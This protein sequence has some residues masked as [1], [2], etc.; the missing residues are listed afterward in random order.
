M[1][2]RASAEVEGKSVRA[3]CFYYALFFGP[4]G[5]LKRALF[6]CLVA[7]KSLQAEAARDRGGLRAQVQRSLSALGPE[8]ES[9]SPASGY[10]EE[11]DD[12]E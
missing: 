9:V 4:L 11:P 12:K 8:M 5:R 10:L 7:Y 6:A 3:E 2:A 1:C